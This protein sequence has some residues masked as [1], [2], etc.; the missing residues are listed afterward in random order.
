MAEPKPELNSTPPPNFAAIFCVS[1]LIISL[2]FQD[3]LSPNPH[4]HRT[5]R[6]S[7]LHTER[8]SGCLNQTQVPCKGWYVMRGRV[9]GFFQL[10]AMTPP[11]AGAAKR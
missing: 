8:T 5:P 9:G 6:Q 10:E 4:L 11:G 1:E 3:K 7:S 2:Q